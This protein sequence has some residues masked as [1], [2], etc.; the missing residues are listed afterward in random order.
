MNPSIADQVAGARG[1][2]MLFMIF[3]EKKLAHFSQVI[4]DRQD[5]NFTRFFQDVHRENAIYIGPC[6]TIPEFRGQ[7]FY[8]YVLERIVEWGSA[9]GTG[10][11]LICTTMD[12]LPSIA[13]VRKAGFKMIG[14]V[15]YQRILWWSSYKFTKQSDFEG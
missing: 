13:G 14:R 2:P 4:I 1:G 15:D 8:G 9:Q 6:E 3:V 5:R 7:N 12:N 11:A 10:S